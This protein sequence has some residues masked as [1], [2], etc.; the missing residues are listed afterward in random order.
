MAKY[1][2]CAAAAGLTT[3]LL[4]WAGCADPTDTTSGGPSPSPSPSPS[5]DAP[6]PPTPRVRF[7]A[8]GDTG[9]GNLGQAEVAAGIEKICAAQGCDFVVLLGDNIYERGVDGVDDP[10]WQTHFEQ[11]YANIDL[12]FYAVLGNHDYGGLVAG[13]IPVAGL[14]NEWEKGQ[15]EVDY[16]Q[17]S[18]KWR[19]PAAHY[20]FAMA[21]VGFIVLDT[22]SLMWDNTSAGDQAAWLPS[23]IAEVADR[24]WKIVLGHHPYR[25]NGNHGNAGTYDAVE[26]A[27]LDLPIPVDQLNGADLKDFLDDNVCGIGDVYLAGHDHARQWLDMPTQ[28]CGMELVVSGA[29]A[30]A[31]SLH[32]HGN[33]AHFQDVS[34]LGFFYADIEGNTMHGRFYNAAGELSYER[35]LTH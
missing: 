9:K 25:S 18:S 11:P 33:A 4:G 34:E 1:R 27:G 3:L 5:P 24:E 15:Y 26:V 14:G 30:S 2:H 31:T 21:H 12:P 6:P 10:K 22:N 17:V 20:T 29:G 32:D 28:L 35:V 16:T 13:F 19:M 7:V 8:V 23:A